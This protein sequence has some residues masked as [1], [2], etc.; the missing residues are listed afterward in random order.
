VE[1]SSYQRRNIFAWKN[2]QKETPTAPFSGAV[3]FMSSISTIQRVYEKALS[4]VLLHDIILFL[5][6][7]TL[8]IAFFNNAEC[9][10]G[11]IS[12]L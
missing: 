9:I 5:C 6:Q 8:R 3:G 11:S 10:I 7:L 2:P 12:L 4:Q 1:E